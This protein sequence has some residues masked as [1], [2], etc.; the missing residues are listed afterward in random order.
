MRACGLI[1]SVHGHSTCLSTYFASHCRHLGCIW[2]SLAS[3]C[4]GL[5]SL[6]PMLFEMCPASGS[7]LPTCP[8]QCSVFLHNQLSLLHFS[9]VWCCTVFVLLHCAHGCNDDK[10]TWLDLHSSPLH[11][12]TPTWIF[13]SGQCDLWPL[14]SVSVVPRWLTLCLYVANVGVGG[15]VGG[16]LGT[17]A[18]TPSS[19]GERRELD[20]LSMWA[21]WLSAVLPH[22]VRTVMS[23]RAA[24]TQRV[25]LKSQP[26]YSEQT[27]SRKPP[28]TETSR[29]ARGRRNQFSPVWPQQHLL[30]LE[31]APLAAFSQLIL[32]P[33]FWG[34]PHC[35]P[36][37]HPLMTRSFHLLFLMS[38]YHYYSLYLIFSLHLF[39]FI[40]FT[41]L[42]IICLYFCVSLCDFQWFMTGDS[43]GSFP[44]VFKSVMWLT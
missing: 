22:F 8:A 41:L 18:P 7:P 29:S 17:G 10:A 28:Q 3:V 21:R 30:Q 33:G 34:H 25:K 20:L 14:N 11:Q 40:H 42:L 38:T 43:F 19:P 4:D 24:L 2:Y 32:P 27:R 1:P 31:A 39:I 44:V 5:R 6:Q 16:D 15:G 23:Q 37:L 9:T 35:R 12:L 36:L 26:I 13:S